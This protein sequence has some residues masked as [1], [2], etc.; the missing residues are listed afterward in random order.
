ML[1]ALC[2]AGVL[3]A[4]SSSAAELLDELT[5]FSCALVQRGAHAVARS[6]TAASDSTRLEGTLQRAGEAADAMSKDA[7]FLVRE[8]SR[9]EEALGHQ[10]KRSPAADP[11]APAS[12][13][14]SE[15]L[16]RAL[17]PMLDTGISLDL[18]NATDTHAV[19]FVGSSSA[20]QSSLPVWMQSAISFGG[21]LTP[22]AGEAV[23][24]S[25]IVLVLFACVWLAWCCLQPA[26]AEPEETVDL[27]GGMFANSQPA[28]VA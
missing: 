9:L 24:G 8:L 16:A 19:G 20:M 17:A 2:F 13:P 11:V 3:L 5:D 18:P 27:F 25:L 21:E 28:N 1:R 10:Q 6:S 26:K 22:V 15:E 14:N 23:W 12:D 4:V 7:E